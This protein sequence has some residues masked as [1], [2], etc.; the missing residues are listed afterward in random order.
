MC[1]CVCVHECACVCV[2][3]VYVCAHTHVIHVCVCV[4]VRAHTYV[5]ASVNAMEHNSEQ[6]N[7]HKVPFFSGTK[8]KR[9]TL[10][11]LSGSKLSLLT[12]SLAGEWS[13]LGDP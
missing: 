7:V 10:T 9:V 6:N 1:V 11:F 3:S 4:C 5:C 12:E 13:F 8:D 2:M